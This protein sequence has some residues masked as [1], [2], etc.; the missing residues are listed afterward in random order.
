MKQTVFQFS[1]RLFH[2]SIS[3]SSWNQLLS[4]DCRGF[5]DLAVSFVFERVWLDD[6]D[7][8]WVE[9]NDP[10]SKLA[11]C[12]LAVDVLHPVLQ[13]PLTELRRHHAE[14]RMALFEH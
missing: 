11:R 4:K 8:W 1:D 2:F 6:E 12:L 7:G 5:S 3:F 10:C 13:V 14:E 9:M